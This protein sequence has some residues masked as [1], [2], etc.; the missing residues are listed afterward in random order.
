MTLRYRSK[1]LHIGVRPFARTR[2][3]RLLDD[4]DVRVI[5]E[6]GELLRHFTIDPEEVRIP[7]A[8]LGLSG[9]SR[10]TRPGCLATQ[11]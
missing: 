11:Q 5:S 2:V 4:L 10:D 8:N 7:G 3:V 1:L 6:E 9:M